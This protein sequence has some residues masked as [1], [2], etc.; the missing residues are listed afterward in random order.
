VSMDDLVIRIKSVVNSGSTVVV[1]ALIRN[2]FLAGFAAGFESSDEGHN[3][4]YLHPVNGAGLLQEDR[5]A[6]LEKFMTEKDHA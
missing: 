1:T 6:A 3:G 5:A 2:I 4:G